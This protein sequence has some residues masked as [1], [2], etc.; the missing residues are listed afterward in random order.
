MEQVFYKKVDRSLFEWGLTFP[1]DFYKYFQKKYSVKLGKGRA[2]KVI[3]DKKTYYVKLRHVKRGG[4]KPIYM[5]RWDN[6]KD[7]LN[8][9]R[10]TFIQSYIILKSQKES[11]DIIKKEHKYFRTRL[12]GGQQE[13]LKVIVGHQGIKFEVFIKI[14]NEWNNLF[15]RLAE[16]NVF[17]WLFD[18]DQKY[19]ISKSTNWLNVKNFAEHKNASNVIYYL[20]NTKKRLLYIGKAEVLGRRVHPKREHQNMSGDWDKFRY[21]IVKSEYSNILDK[22]EDHTIRAFASILENNKKHPSLRLGHFKLVDSNWR[23]L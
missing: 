10:K 19:L 14:E 12:S 21:D 17:G 2:I 5:L 23:K 4:Y 8:K 15:R 1:R 11:F 6:N 7:L 18:K 9:L 3:W 13:I 20:A 16:E 22:I